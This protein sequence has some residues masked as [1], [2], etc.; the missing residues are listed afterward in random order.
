METN[1]NCRLTGIR[2]ELLYICS[3][4]GGCY[5]C[6]HKAVLHGLDK[7]WMFICRDGKMR[8]VINDGKLYEF[9]GVQS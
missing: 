3:R 8:P 1:H 6:D 5:Q 4:C 9:P 7:R 2:N